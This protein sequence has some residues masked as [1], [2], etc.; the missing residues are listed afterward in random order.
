M[1]V[2]AWSPIGNTGFSVTHVPLSNGG[3]GSHRVTSDQKVGISVY[4]VQSA[5]SYWFPGGLDLD[6]LPQ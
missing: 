6:I 3:D 4:G 1:P 2:N 5:G